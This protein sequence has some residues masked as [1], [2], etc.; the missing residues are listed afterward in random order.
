[1]SDVVIPFW[2]EATALVVLLLIMAADLVHIVR[3]PHVPT[4]KE[5]GLWTAF[6][7]GLALFFGFLLF[8]VAGPTAGANSSRGSSPRR[9][10]RSTTCSCSC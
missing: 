6:Y 5:S 7:V 9:A 1:M 8:L 4:P 3:N 10:S 2:F